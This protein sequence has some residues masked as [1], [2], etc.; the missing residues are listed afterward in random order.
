MTAWGVTPSIRVD[1]VARALDFYVGTLGF[2]LE[3]G[4]PA[5]PNSVVRRGD[6]RLMV[7]AA[8]DVYG[9]AYNEAI[10]A[11]LG[12]VS[13]NALYIEAGDVGD[14]HRALQEAGAPV[15]DP[16]GDR[17]W[18]QVEFTVEDPDGNWLTF[19]KAGASG[20]S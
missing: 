8:A 20:E 2:T 5:E 11:R 17:P 14:L 4:G 7:E 13:P 16:L 10:R 15:V 19:W 3:R 9:D 1:D 6:A 18:S 12:S